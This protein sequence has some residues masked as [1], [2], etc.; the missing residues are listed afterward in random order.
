MVSVRTLRW[1]ALAAFV[2]AAI[3]GFVFLRGRT[4]EA[5]QQ[6]HGWVA[7]SGNWTTSGNVVSNAHYG[8]GDM[9][10]IR[11]PNG[12]DYRIAAD[13][14]FN[15]LFQDTHYGD[16]GL[17]IRTSDPEPGVDSYK[18][19]YAGLRPD[20]Q[21]VVLGRASNDWHLLQE[22]K[23]ATPISSGSWYHLEFAARGCSLE[24]TA[25]PPGRGPATQLHYQDLD[26]LTSG[27]AGLRS[28]YTDASWRDV[29]IVS[30]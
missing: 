24:V 26:C 17:I 14:R 2:V 7:I 6:R 22:M 12:S 3:V 10:I 16:A 18:G 5:H 20:S 30:F 11:H 13:V 25:T 15:L 8:R 28:F 9:M 23:L 19:Y 27:D 1:S 21:T 4:A 29:K